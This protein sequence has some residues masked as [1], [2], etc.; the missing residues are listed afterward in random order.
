M[1]KK[2]VEYLFEEFDIYIGSEVVVYI[3]SILFIALILVGM[4]RDGTKEKYSDISQ[5]YEKMRPKTDDKPHRYFDIDFD[6]LF[7]KR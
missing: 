3:V 6:S 2:M 4:L 5:N 1:R 7:P